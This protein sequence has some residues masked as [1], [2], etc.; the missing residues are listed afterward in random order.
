MRQTRVTTNFAAGALSLALGA[1]VLGT[2]I[3]PARAADDDTPLDKKIFRS[4]LEGFGLKRDGDTGINYQERAPLVIPPGKTLPP[5]E[6]SDAAIANSPAWPKDPEIARRKIEAAQERNRNVSEERER[7]QNPL[8]PDQL[9]PGGNPRTAARR[10]QEAAP[11]GEPGDRLDPAGLQGKSRSIWSTMFAKDEPEIGKF[12]GEP[13][14]ASLTTPPPGYQT[15]SPDQPYGLNAKA[16]AP[17]A[18]NYS[19]T[20]G[21]PDGAR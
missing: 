16:N 21:L 1:A 17:K 15:P 8:P 13:P 14:R 2:A 3:L 19:E 11:T 7:E 9:A 20:H 6:R 18:T 5:P 4:I 10:P 12:T